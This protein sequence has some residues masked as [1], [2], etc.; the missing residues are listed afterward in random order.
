M[1]QSGPPRR[2]NRAALGLGAIVDAALADIDLGDWAGRALTEVEAA[3]PAGLAA[4]NQDPMA[5]PHG[6]ESLAALRIR[7]ARWLDG[8]DVRADRVAAVTHAAILRAAIVVALDAPM[9][10]FWRIDVAP[11]SIVRFQGR[12][13]RWTLRSLEGRPAAH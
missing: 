13:G 2:P 11:L 10:A 5:A 6:G 8:L 9:A 7:V 1:D 12:A 3:D 4:W